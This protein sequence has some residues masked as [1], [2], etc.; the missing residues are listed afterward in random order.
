M[1][2]IEG[3]AYWNNITTPNTRYEPVYQT[4]L[5]VPD[6]VAAK[7][8]ADGYSVKEM[9]EGQALVIRRKV[10]KKGGGTN[11]A[12]K[13][14]DQD[15]QPLDAQV[16]NGSRVRVQYRPWETTNS[17]G[18]FKGLDLQC[19]QVLELVEF[20]GALADGEELGYVESESAMDE[21]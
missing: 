21:L 14:L 5:I 12:P 15:K 11:P 7:F 19:M 13:L 4:N 10:A 8:K 20:S 9:N 16:G 6:D 17:Y 3:T 18:S 1:A 2:V